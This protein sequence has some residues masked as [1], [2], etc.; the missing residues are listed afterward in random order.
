VAYKSGLLDSI[1]DDATIGGLGCAHL[2]ISEDF[3]ERIYRL[4]P[5]GHRRV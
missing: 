5:T 4:R 1:E 3:R 2:T